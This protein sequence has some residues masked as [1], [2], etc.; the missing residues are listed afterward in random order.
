MAII[1]GKLWVFFLTLFLREK[2][3]KYFA[4]LIF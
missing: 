4:K 3:G 1:L 2:K